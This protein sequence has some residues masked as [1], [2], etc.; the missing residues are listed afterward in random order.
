VISNGMTAG[1]TLIAI[2]S[3][4]D[5]SAEAHFAIRDALVCFANFLKWISF[6]NDSH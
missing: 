3:I 5:H 6:G 1:P 4:R 2:D